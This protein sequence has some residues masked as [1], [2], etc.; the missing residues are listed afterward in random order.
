[1]GYTVKELLE[2]NEFPGIRL[3]GGEDGIDRKLMRQ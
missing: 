2:S 1:M 3:I